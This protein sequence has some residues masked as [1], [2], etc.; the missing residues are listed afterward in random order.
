MGME[1]GAFHA[2]W[3]ATYGVQPIGEGGGLREQ[4]LPQPQG[5]NLWGATHGGASREQILPQPQ[6]YNLGGG[7]SGS[8]FHP[9]RRGAT[10]GVQPMGGVFREHILPQ[11]HGVQP[12]GGVR[13]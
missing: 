7:G 12:M 11:P 8:T 1:N 4:I 13:E 3:G 2:G 9:G 5:C 6:G 10:Y